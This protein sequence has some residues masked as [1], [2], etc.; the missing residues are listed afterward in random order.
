MDHQVWLADGSSIQISEMD[1]INEPI[2]S[3]L[4]NFLQKMLATDTRPRHYVMSI[5]MAASSKMPTEVAHIPLESFAT[6]KGQP[7]LFELGSGLKAGTE[8]WLRCVNYK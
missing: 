1:V 3:W 4:P 8:L 5:S 6:E 2:S 7:A